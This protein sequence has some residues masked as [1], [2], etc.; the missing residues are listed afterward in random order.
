MNWNKLTPYIEG[1]YGNFKWNNNIAAFDLDGTIVEVKSGKF[2]SID[3]NDWSFFSDTVSDKLQK[4]YN[5]NYSIVIISNQ[6]G[7]SK[8]QITTELWTKK[9]ANIANKLDIP[10]KVYASLIDD[11]YRKP[12]IG[13][14]NLILNNLQLNSLKIDLTKSFYCGDACGRK[15]DH[16]DTDYKFALNSK[17]NFY[18]PECLFLNKTDDNIKV[19][20]DVDFNE[21]K[22][23]NNVV[24]PVIDDKVKDMV[25]MVGYAASGKSS[26]VQ[27]IL[28]PKGYV[29]INMDKLKTKVKCLKECENSLKQGMN[30]VIDNTNPDKTTRKEYIDLAKKYKYNVRCVKMLCDISVASHNSYYRSYKL[31]GQIGHIPMIAYRIYKKKYQEPEKSEGFTDILAFNFAPPTDPNYYMYFY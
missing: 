23:L 22:K 18:S 20:Y 26:I 9:V 29:Q 1:T 14:F 12:C 28:I 19:K 8:G 7:I 4:Y 27:K 6:K 3:E 30:I 24:N 25:I 13:F 5:D 31:N 21:I 2:Y 17:I 10:L 11:I 16:S 15:G